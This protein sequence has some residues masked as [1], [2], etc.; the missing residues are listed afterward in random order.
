VDYWR[1]EGS[2]GHRL[3]LH[4]R[5][6][7]PLRW[8]SYLYVEPSAGV[9]ETAYLMDCLDG[10]EGSLTEKKRFQ[11]RELY[12]LRVGASTELTRVFH[13]DGN[14]WTASKHTVIQEIVYEYIPSLDQEGLPYFDSTDRIDSKNLITYSLTNFFVARLDHAPGKVTYVDFARLKLS[15]SYDLSEAKREVSGGEPS[16]HPFSNVSLELDLA[17]QQY[18]ALTYK[19]DWSPYDGDFKRHDLLAR[20][21]DKRGDSLSIDYREERDESGQVMLD[22]IDGRLSAQLWKGFIFHFHKDYSLTLH[23]NLETEYLLEVKRQCWGLSF[24]YVHQPGDRRFMI[25][26]TLYGVGQSRPGMTAGGS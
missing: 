13:M 3:D 18:L 14:V 24:S 6:A 12:D 1:P 20:L 11:S 9:R 10:P 2:H 25:G 22:E 8:N 7:L 15:Q 23:E 4:P 17:P 21:W 26:F 5:L 16:R 19:S